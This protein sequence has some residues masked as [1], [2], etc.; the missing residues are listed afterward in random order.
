MKNLLD[1]ENKL[2]LSRGFGIEAQPILHNF[3]AK[4]HTGLFLSLYFLTNRSQSSR[5]HMIQ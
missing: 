4:R 2:G 1:N 5:V 3:R